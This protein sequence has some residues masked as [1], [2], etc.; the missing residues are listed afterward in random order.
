VNLK[1]QLN[2][3]IVDK[4]VS[5]AERIA[6]REPGLLAAA[7]SIFDQTLADCSIERTF[8]ETLKAPPGADASARLLIGAHLINF[9]AINHIPAIA[10]GKAAKSMLDTSGYV[11][12]TDKA[13]DR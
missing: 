3:K 11:S 2:W 7:R 4:S 12:P 5:G 1:T 6:L 13:A 10:A 9:S 8:M